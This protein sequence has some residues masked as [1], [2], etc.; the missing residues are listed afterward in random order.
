MTENGRNTFKLY[1]YSQVKQLFCGEDCISFLYYRYR[2]TDSEHDLKMK[3]F[4]FHCPKYGYSIFV[5]VILDVKM[6]LENVDITLLYSSYESA[7]SCHTASMNLPN[8][9]PSPVSII[10]RSQ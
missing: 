8:P 6:C 9:L 10:H 5:R 7:S 3:P 2:H 4:K 1:F